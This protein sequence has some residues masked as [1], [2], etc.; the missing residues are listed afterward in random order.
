[1]AETAMLRASVETETV[2]FRFNCLQKGQPN[3]AEEA[4]G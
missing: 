2:M 4:F 1:M 3:R